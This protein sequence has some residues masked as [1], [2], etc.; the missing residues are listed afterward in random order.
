[1]ELDVANA[2]K[3]VVKAVFIVAKF[4]KLLYVQSVKKPAII[5]EVLCVKTVIRMGKRATISI[6]KEVADAAGEFRE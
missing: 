2:T 5:V 4:V 6:V 3:Q 1:M